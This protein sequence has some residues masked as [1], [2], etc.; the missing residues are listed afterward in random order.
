MEILE[1]EG[2][3]I[4]ANKPRFVVLG[5]KHEYTKKEFDLAANFIRKGAELIGVCPDL[6]DV[7]E[8]GDIEPCVGAW[9]NVN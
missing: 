7:V 5:E 3:K 9:I 4:S 8:D 1:N 2:V 6:Y